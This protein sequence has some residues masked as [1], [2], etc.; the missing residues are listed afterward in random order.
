M[1][2]KLPTKLPKTQK[3][4]VVINNQS[5]NPNPNVIQMNRTKNRTTI[6]NLIKSSG[7][8]AT[9]SRISVA[10]TAL[11]Q[12]KAA[13]VSAADNSSGLRRGN[14]NNIS[15]RTNRQ[16]QLH[17]RSSRNN[18]LLCCSR[19]ASQHAIE[20]MVQDRCSSSRQDTWFFIRLLMR[21]GDI[22]EP[23]PL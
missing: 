9:H 7:A 20:S 17:I 19:S 15:S 4:N 6:T 13:A 23:P 10:A 3:P 2:P 8:P 16:P 22:E 21:N 5:S 12:K 14:N 18:Q 11:R 1:C